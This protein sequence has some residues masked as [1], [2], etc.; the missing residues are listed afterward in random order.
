[1]QLVCIGVYYLRVDD[2]RLWMS[3]LPKLIIF[4]VVDKFVNVVV[5]GGD[6]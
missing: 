3:D 2:D 1:M 5:A 6:E 4:I